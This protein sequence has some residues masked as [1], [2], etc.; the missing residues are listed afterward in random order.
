M[1]KKS[2][3]AFHVQLTCLALKRQFA[4]PVLRGKLKLEKPHCRSGARCT[5]ASLRVAVIAFGYSPF[6]CILLFLSPFHNETKEETRKK[7]KEKGDLIV[8]ES[9][10]KARS[11][12]Q[13]WWKPKANECRHLESFGFLYLSRRLS[14]S[15]KF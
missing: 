5:N 1:R 13:N 12:P 3:L 15:K 4:D 8:R 7:R 2:S 10:I 14:W 6:A 11:Q 9:A